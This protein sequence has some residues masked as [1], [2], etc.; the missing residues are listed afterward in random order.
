MSVVRTLGCGN[1]VDLGAAVAVVGLMQ[2]R[3]GVEALHKDRMDEMGVHPEVR[4]AVLAYRL[5][6]VA[7]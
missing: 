7:Y 4:P 3:Q 5:C 2:I 1:E 6:A